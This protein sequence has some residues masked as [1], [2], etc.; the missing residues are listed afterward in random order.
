M[1]IEAGR[2]YVARNGEKFGPM[3]RF[4]DGDW[5][6]CAPYFH[7]EGGVEFWGYD[8][9]NGGIAGHDRELD[10]IAEWTDGP[11]LTDG[12]VRTVT[13]REVV[14]GVWSGVVIERP[15]VAV[16]LHVH[17]SLHDPSNDELRAAAA[18]LLELAGALDSE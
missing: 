14:P 1:K 9:T 4:P 8:G 12:P 18:V 17:F 2:T 16:N 6:G 13:R 3:V 7:V 5:S 10:L 11:T 15:T